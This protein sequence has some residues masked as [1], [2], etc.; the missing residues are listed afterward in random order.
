[1][2]EIVNKTTIKTLCKKLNWDKSTLDKRDSDLFDM[3]S[4]RSLMFIKSDKESSY[5]NLHEC[6]W[7]TY[8]ALAGD[9]HVYM[10]LKIKNEKVYLH[11]IMYD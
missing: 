3:L 6:K 7:K 10:I 11:G 4:H 2:N 1:M 8:S 5:D 9:N